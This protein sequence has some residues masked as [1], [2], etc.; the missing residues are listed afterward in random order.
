MTSRQF[1]ARHY[2][3]PLFQPEVQEAHD[4]G[5]R[6]SWRAHMVGAALLLS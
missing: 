3:T 2:L 4:N 6:T 1:D 5:L